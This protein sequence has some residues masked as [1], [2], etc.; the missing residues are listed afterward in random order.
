MAVA[1]DLGETSLDRP[2]LEVGGKEDGKPV[3]IVRDPEPHL[4]AS[5]IVGLGIAEAHGRTNIAN[6]CTCRADCDCQFYG[7]VGLAAYLLL[8]ASGKTDRDFIAECVD[9]PL[10]RSSMHSFTAAEQRAFIGSSSNFKTGCP[11]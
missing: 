5:V 7:I 1:R 4:L 11:P 9:F 2:D 6:V 10:L 8:L 3:V